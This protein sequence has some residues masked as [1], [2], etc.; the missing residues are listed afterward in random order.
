MGPPLNRF[1]VTD[2]IQQNNYNNLCV[3][4]NENIKK[5][6]EFVNLIEGQKIFA[7]ITKYRKSVEDFSTTTISYNQS[8][9]SY[10]EVEIEY[11]R[12]LK[13]VEDSNNEVLTHLKEYIFVK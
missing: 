9:K 5:L 3:L 4:V 13:E 12:I 7:I 11:R 6:S 8:L 2:S 1:T 10:R